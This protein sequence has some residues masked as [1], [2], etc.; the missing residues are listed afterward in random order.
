MYFV[1]K[2]GLGLRVTRNPGCSRARLTTLNLLDDEKVIS[3]LTCLFW[4]LNTEQSQRLNYALHI[5]LFCGVNKVG[6]LYIGNALFTVF[7]DTHLRVTE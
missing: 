1:S 6:Y 2:A 5:R 4:K 3:S 7:P